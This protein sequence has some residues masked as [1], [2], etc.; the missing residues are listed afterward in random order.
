MSLDSDAK[1]VKSARVVGDVWKISSSRNRLY[2]AMVKCRKILC[3][4]LIDG[5]G[6]FGSRDGDNAANEIYRGKN[7]FAN[8]LLDEVD[9]DCFVLAKL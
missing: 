1:P 9:S 7:S 2:E 4:S 5:Q 6:N 8:V 3:I